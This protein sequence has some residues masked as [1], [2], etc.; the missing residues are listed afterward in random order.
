MSPPHF[1]NKAKNTRFAN[2]SVGKTCVFSLIGKM[3]I[4]QNIGDAFEK[5]I[6]SI[7]PCPIFLT[8]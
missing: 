1:A 6:F 2:K 7:L 4:W 8:N 3:W 5:D